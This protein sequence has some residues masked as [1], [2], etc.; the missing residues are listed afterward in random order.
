CGATRSPRNSRP[1]IAVKNGSTPNMSSAFATVVRLSA[2]MK[3]VSIAAQARLE[4]TP[5]HPIETSLRAA[6]PRCCASISA[7]T[8]TPRNSERQ[9]AASQ[10]LV[11][12]DARVTT[13]AVLQRKVHDT[14]TAMPSRCCAESFGRGRDRDAFGARFF[15]RAR[16]EARGFRVFHD[17][18]QVRETRVA[19][20]WHGDG[21][22]HG[23]EAPVHDPRPGQFPAH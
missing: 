3:Q 9:N 21:L 13:P 6:A 12:E 10:P 20:L 23:H 4:T 7:A 1:A 8:T 11:T 2:S 16:H 14:S 15:H 18:A 17:A 22:L 5:G 19:T